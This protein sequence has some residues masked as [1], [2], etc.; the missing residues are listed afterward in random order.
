MI[1]KFGTL[2]AGHVDLGD[3]GFDATPANSRWLNEN[4]LNSVYKNLW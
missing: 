3:M 2:Y 4:R 1:K